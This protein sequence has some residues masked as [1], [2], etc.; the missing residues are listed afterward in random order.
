MNGFTAYKLYLAMKLHFTKL[1]YDVFLNRGYV[2][3]CTLESYTKKRE[4][5][6]FEML[7]KKFD[8]P[9]EYIQYLV[10]QCAYDEISCIFDLNVSMENY[11]KWKK[12]KEM[13]TRL[14]LD[15]LDR[16]ELTSSV[17]DYVKD[18][19]RHIISGDINIETAVALNRYFHFLGEKPPEDY[20]VFDD[21]AL[22]LKKL[23]KFIKY[24]AEVVEA[25]IKELASHDFH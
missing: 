7:A 12:N 25:R 9:Q 4:K 23:D 19:Y 6:W 22:K 16:V 11:K 8:N 20:F 1:E 24:K 13:L 3:N 15:D 10:A 14:I 18:I 2:A 17:T 21:L 5:K